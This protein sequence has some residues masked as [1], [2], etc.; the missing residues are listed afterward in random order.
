M[1][2]S[3]ETT[4]DA[5]LSHMSWRG[6]HGHRRGEE[7]TKGTMHLIMRAAIR[8]PSNR[9]KETPCCRGGGYYPTIYYC[10]L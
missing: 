8:T 4:I 7:R 9:F 3:N 2:D 1:S 6:D 10:W 5:L